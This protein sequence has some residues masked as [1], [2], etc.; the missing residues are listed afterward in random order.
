M[1]GTQQDTRPPAT[2][3]IQHTPHPLSSP[4]NGERGFQP[5][6]NNS[7]QPL[8]A[9]LMPGSPSA[10]KVQ[11]LSAETRPGC[12]TSPHLWTAVACHRFSAKSVLMKPTGDLLLWRGFPTPPLFRPVRSPSCS[13]GVSP[14]RLNCSSGLLTAPPVCRRQ[15][16]PADQVSHSPTPLRIPQPNRRSCS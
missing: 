3:R 1:A 5:A 7:G 11:C 10:F 13:A 15:A 9:F 4:Q 8:S 6:L 14:E 16:L 12:G 2:F